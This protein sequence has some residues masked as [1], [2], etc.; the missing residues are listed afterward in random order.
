MKQSKGTFIGPVD[1]V[2]EKGA[3]LVF[4]LSADGFERGFVVRFEGRIRAYR[5]TCPHAGSQL[6]WTEGDFFDH[7]G[8]YLICAT[9]G[10]LFDPLSGSCVQG[11]CLGQKLERLPIRISDDGLWLSSSDPK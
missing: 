6:D 10:A 1:Q 8:Q 7:T 3:A 9:H 11:P 2:A 5:N 4:D